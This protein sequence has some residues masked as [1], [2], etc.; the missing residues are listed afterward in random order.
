MRDSLNTRVSNK[1]AQL[2]IF[3]ARVKHCLGRKQDTE[4]SM[5]QL[6]EARKK[7]ESRF[8]VQI[9]E[10][11]A[12]SANA[13]AHLDAMR[14]F[15]AE[16]QHA[17][18]QKT[19]LDRENLGVEFSARTAHVHS[20]C[21]QLDAEYELMQSALLNAREAEEAYRI[22][23][24]D[25]QVTMEHLAESISMTRAHS[26]H[27]AVE[28]EYLSQTTE[29]ARLRNLISHL[30]AEK[31]FLQEDT[32]RALAQRN[33]M[34]DSLK[35]QRIA[36]AI[37]SRVDRAEVLQS[38]M[39]SSPPSASEMSQARVPPPSSPSTGSVLCMIDTDSK[40]KTEEE[41]TLVVSEKGVD[42]A[43]MTLLDQHLS[44]QPQQK[45]QE[46]QQLSA[47][48]VRSMDVAPA[49]KSSLSNLGLSKKE[50]GTSELGL[51]VKGKARQ[52]PPPPKGVL[53]AAANLGSDIDKYESTTKY[54]AL[55]AAAAPPTNA[56]ISS[57]M[58]SANRRG[59][60]NLLF[61]KKELPPAP[62]S[63]AAL[64]ATRKKTPLPTQPELT[65]SET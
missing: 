28:R 44:L 3:S 34:E 54:V 61:G 51:T 40:N 41:H 9:C 21:V 1:R 62:P 37:S 36:D 49:V 22:Q 19:K 27:S 23:S 25:L 8:D 50:A 24:L 55:P 13:K 46:L 45:Q 12:W 52:P 33:Y 20:K 16:Q 32:Y 38:P 47:P 63:P 7:A 31:L 65:T 26:L 48:A 39:S 53:K 2:A 4:L 6:A 59:T 64:A 43:I 11:Q 29:L 14:V 17:T 5:A 58:P 42:N 15:W 56:V 57:V 60:V 35:K 30:Q 18:E 10:Q